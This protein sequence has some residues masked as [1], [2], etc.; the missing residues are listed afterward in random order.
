V[1]TLKRESKSRD[2]Q[3]CPDVVANANKGAG[4]TLVKFP[5]KLSG[6]LPGALSSTYSSCQ[7]ESS[8]R[9]PR[10]QSQEGHQY[11]CEAAW[12]V[13]D[14]SSTRKLAGGV[15]FPASEREIQPTI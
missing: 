8:W 1:L 2:F 4:G 7:P 15:G 11:A 14:P 13:W 3:L 9:M 6:C 10:Y 5:S 12:Q